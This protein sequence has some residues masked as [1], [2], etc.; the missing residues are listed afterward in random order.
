ME[1]KPKFPHETEA[2]K[3]LEV[4]QALTEQ[5]LFSFRDRVYTFEVEDPS[6]AEPL[7]LRFKKLRAKEYWA[8]LGKLKE[9]G[10]D[11]AN[12]AGLSKE[13]GEQFYAIQCLA[14]GYASAD[15]KNAQDWLELDDKLIVDTCF[16]YLMQIT[17]P[18]DNINW[19]HR[20]QK[21][22]EPS[23]LVSKDE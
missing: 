15:G 8:V 9:S 6:G 4:E 18:R 13:H 23:S 2:Y 5:N 14:L 3:R 11:F 22:K 20:G 7:K 1:T 19:F 16:T 17:N 12:Q 21:G 10:I